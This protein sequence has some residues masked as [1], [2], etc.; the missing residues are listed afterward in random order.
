LP[1]TLY[2]GN[3]AWNVTEDD[4]AEAF[5]TCTRVYDARVIAERFTG[6]SRGFGFVDVDEHDV[7]Q[8]LRV[9]NDYELKG[10]KIRVNQAQTRRGEAQR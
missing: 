4:L 7:E 5:G 10:R 1:A 3:L 6:R 2:V 8:V 9:M